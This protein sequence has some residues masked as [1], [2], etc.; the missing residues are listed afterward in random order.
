MFQSN[1]INKYSHAPPTVT[2][3]VYLKC[4]L[5]HFTSKTW[6]QPVKVIFMHWEGLIF[7][8]T[9]TKRQFVAV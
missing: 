5:L 7:S 6:H 8:D 9:E 4:K 3:T 2:P 1:M